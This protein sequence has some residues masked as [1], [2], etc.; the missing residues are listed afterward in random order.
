[1][2][3]FLIVYRSTTSPAEMFATVTPQ[4]QRAFVEKWRNW[5]DDLGG[6]LIDRGSLTRTV[7]DPSADIIFGY[8]IVEA[9]DAQTVEQL[10]SLHPFVQA[11]GT[12]GVHECL[13]I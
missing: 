9:P 8:A 4:R 1:M 13:M 10:L 11:G 5:S 2:P 7:S 6:S 12:A 3:K